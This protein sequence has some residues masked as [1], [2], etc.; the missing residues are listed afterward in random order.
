MLGRMTVMA[1]VPVSDL[2]RASTFYGSVL[3]LELVTSVPGVVAVFDA[4]GTQREPSIAACD[5][6]NPFPVR[7]CSGLA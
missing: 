4:G 5:L 1:F 7:T 6:E 3:D 2:E